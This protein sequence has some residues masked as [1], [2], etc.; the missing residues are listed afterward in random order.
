M[1]EELVQ[2]RTDL[3]HAL[4]GLFLHDHVRDFVAVGLPVG[5]RDR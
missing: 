1:A 4:R 2:F 5:F 3:H